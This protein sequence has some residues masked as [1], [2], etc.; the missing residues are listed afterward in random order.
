MGMGHLQAGWLDEAE[1]CF[2]QALS[3]A[4]GDAG[5]LDLLGVV[6]LHRRRFAEAERFFQ[7]ALA[8]NDGEPQFYN[9]LAHAFK[10]QGKG[11]EARKALEKAISIDPGSA[12]AHHN[13]G[14]LLGEMSLAE[15]A[16][17]AYRKAL[18]L[19]PDDTETL[20]ELGALLLTWGHPGDAEAVFR[21]R[22]VLDP[23]DS[24]A[25]GGLGDAL[26]NQG[27]LEEAERV[28]KRALSIPNAHDDAW[29]RY[30][31]FLV[32]MGRFGEAEALL[33]AAIRER[34]EN[35]K[36]YYGLCACRKLTSDDRELLD[37]IESLVFAESE[38]TTDLV[39]VFYSLGKA[40]NDL[41]DY[42][43]AFRCY[44]KAN[45]WYGSRHPFNRGRYKQDVDE[46]IE[47]FGD[48]FLKQDGW[49]SDSDMPILI[50]G[51]PRS[52]TT[53][54]EQII[55]SHPMVHGAGELP[56]WYDAMAALS[57]D[58]RANLTE[59]RLRRIGDDYLQELEKYGQGSAHVTDKMPSNYL[60]LG[61][62]HRI[63]PKAK[64]IHCRRNPV[65]AC[66]SIYFQNFGERHPY[67]FDLGNL[68]F[69][70]RQY[71]RLMQHWRKVLP[72]HAMLEIQYEDLVENQEEMSR[73]LIAFCGLE[74]DDRCLEFYK[75][76]RQVKTASQWQVRQPMYKSS[77]ERWRNYEPYIGPL[78]K[79]MEEDE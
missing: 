57:G 48:E 21:R 78:L 5:L 54:T 23:N 43:R 51:T 36:F 62:I 49:R 65:D 74:W 63:F 24:L 67:R 17:S 7:Q 25:L 27:L 31:Q 26:E 64:I 40:Y 55:S 77:K 58:F 20:R 9:H 6:E 1:R 12:E 11:A 71:R 22:L 79:L 39:G 28:F 18:E 68:A 4:T 56:F 70:Y 45:N 32:H 47:V 61:L 16:I 19:R 73:K 29:G 38:L 33:T 42:E 44:E 34:G 76:E 46:L 52:G 41:G 15:E 50:V 75:S 30:G 8:R 37:K 3:R 53:L 2:R 72:A 10:G 14:N 60:N 59:E 13:L 35:P 69:M 66:L